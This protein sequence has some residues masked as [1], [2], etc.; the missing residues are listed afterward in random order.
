MNKISVKDWR[1]LP[2]ESWTVTTFRQYL[3]DQHQTKLGIAYITKGYQREGSMLKS[4]ISQF[5]NEATR[6]FIDKCLNDYVP[7]KDYPGISYGFMYA[8]VRSRIMPIV[9]AELKKKQAVQ[10]TEYNDKQFD[11]D[12]L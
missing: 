2:I 8:Y 1:N 10:K 7:K 5:G 4:T 11:D 3:A 6:L 9:L 12:W